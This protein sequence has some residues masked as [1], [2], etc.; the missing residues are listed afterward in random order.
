[1]F[2]PTAEK[3]RNYYKSK[4]KYEFNKILREKGV[5]IDS[6]KTDNITILREKLQIIESLL[7]DKNFTVENAY[8]VTSDYDFVVMEDN[9]LQGF[10]FEITSLLLRSKEYVLEKINQLE[11]FNTVTSLKDAIS[12]LQ[13]SDVRIKL[14]QKINELQIQNEELLRVK[15]QINENFNKEI[16]FGKHK[17]E[18]LEKRTNI[19]LK[20][21]DKESIASIVGAVLLLLM[22]ISLIIM[23]FYEINP[24]QIVQSAFLLILGYFFGHSKNTK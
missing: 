17:V 24:I 19:F 15:E 10:Y 16:E 12:E 14:E 22:G 2:F 20:F 13:E 11:Q 3:A 6:V 21:L 7:L 23:M 1:M 5:D 4:S 8:I 18:I 9:N